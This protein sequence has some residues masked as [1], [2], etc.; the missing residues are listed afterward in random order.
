VG[1]RVTV[2][3]TKKEPMVFEIPHGNLPKF[4]EKLEKL[5]KRAKKVGCPPLKVTPGKQWSKKYKSESLGEVVLEMVEVTIEGETPKYEGW[6]FLATLQPLGKTL[7]LRAVPG[8][9]VPEK[10]READPRYCDHCKKVRF[11]KETFLV[12]HEETGE[13]KQVGRQCIQDFLG[14]M[15]PEWLGRLAELLYRVPELAE[16]AAD[17]E[18]GGGWGSGVFGY[19]IKRFLAMTAV[20]MDELGWTSRGKAYETNLLATADVVLML[21]SPKPLPKSWTRYVPEEKH[22]EEADTALEW[23]KNLEAD[24]DKDYLWNLKQVASVDTITHKEAGLAASMI[25]AYRR[26]K[27]WD[28]EKAKKEAE[29]KKSEWVGE[30]GKR[31][32]FKDC[33]FQ[34]AISYEGYWGKGYLMK[35]VDASGN[36]IVTFTSNP[37]MV[38]HVNIEEEPE[39]GKSYDLV[40]TVKKHETYRD[41]EQTVLTRARINSKCREKSKKKRVPCDH[42]HCEGRNREEEAA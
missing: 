33:E 34:I 35:F 28:L 27:E 9:K 30:E 3:E 15:K 40:G 26:G 13:Y 24:I 25:M 23:A 10:F 29:A 4:L 17:P 11:R 2:E 19:E 31:G 5:N 42:P 41:T 21:L 1:R 36:V 37:N 8:A 12:K 38:K 20:V 18:W 16:E 22:R 14:G 39:V 32:T 6:E 7:L